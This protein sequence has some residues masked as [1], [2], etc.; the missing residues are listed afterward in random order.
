VHVRVPSALAYPSYN[1]AQCVHKGSLS[2]LSLQQRNTDDTRYHGKAHPHT[3]P[4]YHGKA[5]P[6]TAPLQTV[7][8]T[9]LYN[10][11]STA[12]FPFDERVSPLVNPRFSHETVND[13]TKHKG[14]LEALH[15]ILNAVSFHREQLDTQSPYTNTPTPY[16]VMFHSPPLVHVSNNCIYSNSLLL[17][18]Y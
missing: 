18:H 7:H 2:E 16:N 4:E 10:E 9:A 12:P 5:H 3:A 1:G 15:Y 8:R 11:S 13:L 6:H 17:L 14:H